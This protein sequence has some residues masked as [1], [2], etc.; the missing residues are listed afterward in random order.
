MTDEANV[1][2]LN[3]RTLLVVI[4][5]IINCLI[6]TLTF[7]C[8]LIVVFNAI[9]HDSIKMSWIIVFCNCSFVDFFL[10][11]GTSR[12]SCEKFVQCVTFAQELFLH[13]LCVDVVVDG[14]CFKV[15]GQNRQCK[16]T[17]WNKTN[18]FWEIDC[19]ILLRPFL[20]CDN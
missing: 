13:K 3:D 8:L 2:L 18:R 7:V 16:L 4:I 14:C 1:W 6:W 10:G 17:V 5:I 19:L 20:R 11:C 15:S 12:V 9:F